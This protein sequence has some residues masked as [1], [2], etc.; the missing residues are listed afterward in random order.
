MVRTYYNCRYFT[1][2]L[3]FCAEIEKET[4]VLKCSVPEKEP[5]KAAFLK[6][7]PIFAIV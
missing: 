7:I 6:N 1:C 5:L 4:T 2:A 3:V